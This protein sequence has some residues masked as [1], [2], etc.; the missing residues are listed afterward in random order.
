MS[1]D[2]TPGTNK[3]NAD[4]PPALNGHKNGVPTPPPEARSGSVK[5]RKKKRSPAAAAPTPKVVQ[6]SAP[7]PA[8][9]ID[10][11]IATAPETAPPSAEV[12]TDTSAETG[13]APVNMAP[14][15][16]PA[17]AA[18]ADAASTDVAPNV[19]E[20]LRLRAKVWTD[21]TTGKRYLMPTAF[22]RDVVNGQPVSDVMYAYAMSDEETKLVLL[23][24]HEWNTLPFFYFKED[25]PAP[26][27]SVRS[28]DVLVS[29]GS[30]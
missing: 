23:R 19:S 15:E 17:D 29:S 1:N 13:E 14:D 21:Q 26:R 30:P 22:M 7:A 6:T 12:V 3:T 25:G 4:P 11:S 9:E 8:P 28:V 18:P 20:G 24:A 27:A 10:A 2:N 5:K 16:A